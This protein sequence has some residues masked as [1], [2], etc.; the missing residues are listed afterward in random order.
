MGGTNLSRCIDDA[1]P[2]FILL[3]NA[4]GDFH[5][6]TGLNLHPNAV[7]TKNTSDSDLLSI[8]NYNGVLVSPEFTAFNGDISG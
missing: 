4:P 7:L 2:N 1:Y 5:F 6:A 8:D 3:Q